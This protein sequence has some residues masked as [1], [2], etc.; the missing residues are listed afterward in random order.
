MC[1][2]VWI[3]VPHHE[4]LSGK[5]IFMFKEDLMGEWEGEREQD[6][7]KE[8]RGICGMRKANGAEKGHE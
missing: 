6:Q 3:L 1:P 4:K 8:E 7:R 2:E 5:V